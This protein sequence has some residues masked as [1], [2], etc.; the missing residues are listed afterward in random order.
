MDKLEK[1]TFTTCAPHCG[2][3]PCSF[4]V[5]TKGEEI[6]S[7]RANPRMDIKPCIKGF[8]IP[9]RYNH[10]DRVLYPMKRVGKKGSGKNGYNNF[11]RIS[12]D[13]AITSIANG[14]ED[15]KNKGG[16]NSIL[17]YNYS[18]QHTLPGGR[19]AAPATIMRLLNLW[20]G[21]IEAFNRGSL[22]WSAFLGAS[23]DVLGQWQIK[24]KN[25]DEC[26]W[27]IL[28]GNNPIETG[29]RGLLQSLQESKRQGTKFIVVD[30]MRTKTVERFA[31][32]HIPIEP[33]TDTALA[34]GVLRFVLKHNHL[35]KNFLTKRTNAPFLV[36]ESDGK[37]IT[38]NNGGPLVWDTN[39]KKAVHYERSKNP[40]LY[41]HKTIN[42][43]KCS[44]AFKL[45]QK[46]SEKWTEEAVEKE[47]GIPSSSIKDIASAL[48]NG[49]IIVYYGAYQRTFK[50]ENAVRALHI[51][52]LISGGIEGVL[53]HGSTTHDYQPE[54]A[55]ETGLSRVMAENWSIPNPVKRTVPIGKIA[56]AILKPETYGGPI[57][58]GLFMW[59]NPV[60]QGGNTN[61]TKKALLSL[62]FCVVSDIFLTPTAKCSDIILPATTWLERCTISEGMEVGSTFYHLIE[63]RKPKHQIFY[64]PGVLNPLG[65]AMDDFD[66][67]CR[68]AEKMG[69][70]E[71]FPW[72]SSK[73]W[74]ENLITL[75]NKD[76]RFP[77]FKNLNIED[78]EKKGVISLD[79]PEGKVSW[80]LKT[81]HGR[82][83]IYFE[84]KK[85]PVPEHTPPQEIMQPEQMKY[86][87]KLITPKTYFRASSTFNNAKKLL[88]HHFNVATVN[89]E[90]AKEREIRNGDSI[91]LFNDFGE[92]QFVARTTESI[93]QGVV[94]I[95][96]GGD[97]EMG[98]ANK[99][100]G[101][102]LSEYENA[103][104]NSYRIELEK[105]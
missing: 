96:A 72:T 5:K 68:L 55:T 33:S 86:P 75:A 23:D 32:I 7:F 27:I 90:D 31:D 17:M 56:E 2:N 49:K 97:E 104:F 67:I 14:L 80:D 9:D 99:L 29:Y 98:M 16:N 102:I 39:L 70:K 66:F 38:D 81:K 26:D 82:A 59:G 73:Q 83:Q 46:S 51:L 20:G 74:I 25:S 93:R 52:N 92:T 44:T 78:L 77:W 69:F 22:C 45:L 58:A 54:R 6:I 37:F 12:W 85:H 100:T 19:D 41:A 11:E 87:L 64:S 71:F 10:P 18:S 89:I 62:D 42:E 60:G 1:S 34:L 3:Y 30:P 48:T 101:D 40:D 4:E 76:S 61:K 28:W 65:E 15:A 50:G 103:T 24:N 47:C 63:E 105:I 94:H 57:H 8:Q 21:A 43:E 36:R 13:E 88:R 91:R 79:I 53:N 84:D 35:N 95:P